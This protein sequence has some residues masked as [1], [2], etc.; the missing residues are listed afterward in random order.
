MTWL[1]LRVFLALESLQHGPKPEVGSW[2]QGTP[3][4][5]STGLKVSLQWI[6]EVKGL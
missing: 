6:V 5:H 4:S 2:F 1:W 3:I